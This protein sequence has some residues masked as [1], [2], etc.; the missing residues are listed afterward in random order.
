M[1]NII[2]NGETQIGRVID[3]I[4]NLKEE[5]IQIVKMIDLFDIATDAN[6]IESKQNDIDLILELVNGLYQD[7]ITDKIT[8]DTIIE[9]LYNPMGCY[10]YVKYEKVEE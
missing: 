1:N 5:M 3:I 8:E 6:D 4:E 7:V 2:D 9:V 10:Q